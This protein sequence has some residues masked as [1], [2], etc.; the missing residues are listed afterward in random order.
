MA[1]IPRGLLTVVG[2]LVF[3]PGGGSAATWQPSDV[4]GRFFA[5]DSKSDALVDGDANEEFDVFLRDTVAGT[6]ALISTGLDGRSGN[7]TSWWPLMSSTGRFLV[8]QSFASNL[9]QGDSTGAGDIFLRDLVLN[10]TERVSVG[11]D[12]AQANDT[13]YIEV[14][15]GYGSEVTSDGRY[16]AFYSYASNLV[17]GDANRSYDVFLR[18]R[19]AGTT[20]LVSVSSAEVQGNSG[21]E[22][23]GMSAD[24]RYVV[25]ESFANNLV[26]NDHNQ[27]KDIFVRDR[28]AG[29][30]ELVSVGSDEEL[31]NDYSYAADVSADGRYIA[32]ESHSSNLVP[33]DSNG[34]N[35][36]F[37][38][39]RT[40]GTTERVSLSDD[41]AQANSSGYGSSDPSISADG[42]LVVFLSWA[43]NL[44]PGDTNGWNDIFVRDRSAGTTR[45]VSVTR[46]GLQANERSFQATISPNGRLVQFKSKATNLVG[47]PQVYDAVWGDTFVR[48]LVAGTTEQISVPTTPAQPGRLH[49]SPLNPRSGG[50]LTAAF[51][52][53]QGSKL[54]ASASVTCTAVVGRRKPRLIASGYRNGTARCAWLVPVGSSGKV[55]RGRIVATTPNGVVERTFRTRAE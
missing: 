23:E 29:T 11:R 21:S 43:S 8:F 38:R 18:D 5:F 42:R 55:I 20:E 34:T 6:T 9:V 41:G 35:D 37:I 16:I 4:T 51:T 44:V 31:G 1:A 49:L 46:G 53:K 13:S 3:L 2:L 52:V 32:F 50:R 40:R 33:G 12:G 36:V 14:S 47:R 17:E 19:V 7:E 27:T 48:D 26:P 15:S 22:V 54:V 28:L 24:G 39:D 25:F 45:R 10:T 30:T